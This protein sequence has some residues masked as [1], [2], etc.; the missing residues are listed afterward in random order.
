MKITT[1]GGFDRKGVPTGTHVGI[2]TQIV[3]LGEQVDI[4]AEIEGTTKR[5][6][7]ITFEIPSEKL[8][9]GRPMVIGQEVTASLGQKSRLRPYIES[10]LGRQLSEGD[11][12]NPVEIL[13]SALGKPGFI[14]VEEVKTAKG[15]KFSKIKAVV[16]MPK[17]TTVETPFNDL[18]FIDL[19]DRNVNDHLSSLPKFIQDKIAASRSTPLATDDLGI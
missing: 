9:D 1:G 12:A 2:L 15:S 8:D 7:Y 13:K 14:Q 18:V 6:L 4:F 19:D 10:L 3:D 17:G 11:L 16:P 5:K